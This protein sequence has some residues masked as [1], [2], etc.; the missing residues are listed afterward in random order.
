MST[1]AVATTQ[2]ILMILEITLT[3]PDNTSII[4]TYTGDLTTGGTIRNLN[5]LWK[6][7]SELDPKFGYYPKAI[8]T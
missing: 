4:A 8:K 3:S 5:D 1:Y 7:S 2:L 6:I